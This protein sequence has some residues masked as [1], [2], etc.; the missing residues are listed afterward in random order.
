MK[1][2]GK[3]D[4]PQTTANRQSLL[5]RAGY[6]RSLYGHWYDE[7]V[8]CLP[9]VPGDVL[10]LGSGGGFLAEVIP[11]LRTSDVMPVPGV[12][13]AIDARELP[14]A[15]ASLRAIVGTNVLHHV[16]QI[17]RFLSEAQ[18]T[19]VD[20]GRLVFIEPWPTPLSKLVY[21]YLHHEPFDVARDWSIP[22]GGPL[23]AAN[24]A[25][26]WI[27][28]QRDRE[29][30]EREFPHLAVTRT[31][32]AMPFSYLLSGGIGRAWRLPSTLFRVARLLEAPLDR[33]GLFALIVIERAPRA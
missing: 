7:I 30:F 26:P 4:D 19:L 25:L 9:D 5:R 2:P 6:L 12:E 28:F 24:G 14:F 22:D 15:D 17:E 16:P 18:R 11:G 32:P 8:G 13:L 23:T 29:R 21:A 27:V 31:S 3:L 20:G 33:L 1:A 10:E